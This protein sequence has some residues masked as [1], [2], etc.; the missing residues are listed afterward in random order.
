MRHQEEGRSQ[1]AKEKCSQ[2]ILLKRP[3]P[4]FSIF[5][6]IDYLLCKKA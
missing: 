2:A 1:R 5:A 3:S 6:L 4:Q